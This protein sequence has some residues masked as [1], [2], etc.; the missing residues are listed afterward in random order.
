MPMQP[1]S[2]IRM[3]D[4]SH[5][6]GSYCGRLF[7]DVGADVI[8]VEPP[9]GL[10]D[11]R[12]ASAGAFAFLN[13]SKR[14]VMME[15]EGAG[16]F[17][18]FL[19]LARRAQVVV[20]ERE[21]PLWDRAGDLCAALPGLVVT[22]VSPFGRTGPMAA[23]PASDL[24]L[25]AAGGIAWLSG[26]VGRAPLRLPFGQAAMVAGTYAA[27]ATAMCLRDAERR[28]RGHLIDISAQE[29]IGHSLQ[30]AVQVWDLEGRIST[31]GG[32]GTRD[33]TEDIFPCRDG[34]V[35]LAAPLALPNS[36]NGVMGWMTERGHP[37]ADALRAPCWQDREW[38]KTGTARARFFDLFTAFSR[39]LTM[40]EL[41]KG[42]MARKIV[43][44]PV[45]RFPDLAS[46]PQLAHRGFF[47][48][49]GGHLFPGPPYLSSE[50]VWKVAQ[51]PDLGE[52]WEDVA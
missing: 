45:A 2:G 51:A 11:R 19:A 28:G 25:Q 8:R 35:F 36:W 24:T 44:A 12:R 48:R 33:A 6:L 4:L 14:S 34:H 16:G 9:G 29:A 31:R 27:T 47:R 23:A 52:R 10:A 3:L 30:N 37:S 41:R 26:R 32:E 38:R 49:V 15:M 43:M 18:R 46:D 40:A 5:W 20:L 13:A 42:A 7:A 17:S 50:P 1:Y 21:G 22:C 39:A